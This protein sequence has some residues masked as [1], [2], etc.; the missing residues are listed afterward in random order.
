VQDSSAAHAIGRW[1]DRAARRLPLSIKC[2]P[3]AVA[4]LW[5]L[6]RRGLDARLVIAVHR[7]ER[8]GEHAFHAWV[9]HG[10]EFV[11]G[12]CVRED[13]APVMTIGG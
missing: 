11:V 8:S 3:R 1:I 10:D 13:Y 7:Q 6:S 5:L 2:L 4:A 12:H 9:E